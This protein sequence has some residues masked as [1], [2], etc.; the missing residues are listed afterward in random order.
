VLLG[1]V[2][3]A[4]P[5]PEEDVMNRTIVVG[6]TFTAAALL[7][8]VVSAQ[9]PPPQ[10][11]AAAVKQSLAAN[12]AALHHYA[13]IETTTITV[14]G[15]VKK[16][17]EKQCYYGAD[18]K[19]Q[20]TPVPGTSTPPA[21]KAAGGGRRGRLKEAIVEKKV[22]ELKDYMERAAALVHSYVP[23][24]PEKIQAAQAAGHFTVEPAGNN[25]T[26]TITDYLKPNDKL[27]I[28]FDTAAKQLTAYAVNS[29]VDKPKDDDVTLAVTFGRLEDGTSYPQQVV[30]NV[31][32]KKIQVKV[33][34]GGYKKTS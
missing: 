23:P 2:F 25:A 6:S 19:V 9:A 1:G 4:S 18:G 29:Y 21:P 13:W 12:Q 20:K 17:E 5:A 10:D 11:R 22:D 3:S 30:L 32:A 26:L 34:N 8:T 33:V 15:E 27:A 24:D 7:V 16:Q 14:K 31:V 28:G